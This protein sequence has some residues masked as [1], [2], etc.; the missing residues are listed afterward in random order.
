MMILGFF[1]I[2]FN[3]VSSEVNDGGLTHDHQLWIEAAFCFN[4]ATLT[5]RGEN[6][7]DLRCEGELPVGVGG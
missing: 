1:G 7:V 5:Y 2:G 4:W 6:P 3:G